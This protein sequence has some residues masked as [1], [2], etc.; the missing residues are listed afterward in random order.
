VCC[1]FCSLFQF[2][3]FRHLICRLFVFS[4]EIIW[5]GCVHLHVRLFFIFLHQF[6][7]LFVLAFKVYNVSN[8]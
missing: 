1:V 6:S 4:G 5:V 7:S 2:L 3:S 8:V